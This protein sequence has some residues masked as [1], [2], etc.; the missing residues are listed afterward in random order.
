MAYEA[1]GAGVE[2]GGLRDTNE[3]KILVCWL[4][5]SVGGPL[6][7]DNL[8]EILA[9][10]GLVN[11]FELAQAVQNLLNSG[12]IDLADGES[13]RY[14][15][16]KLGAGTAA[17]FERRLPRS[18][19]DKAA[20]DA[21]RL[22]ARIRREAENRAEIV[23]EPAGGYRVRCR[24]LDRGD[25]LLELNLLVPTQEQAQLVKQNFTAQAES[26]YQG[27]LALL[28]GESAASPAA[29]DGDAPDGPQKP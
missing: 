2:P 11:Y 5:K 25:A 9:G 13:E 3:V 19:R 6:S 18:V 4:L 27:V 8:N 12:H 20:R 10:D 17:L 26:V 21:V 23:S 14:R 15:C 28:A 29:A 7:F 24:I 16:T 1:M 22:L